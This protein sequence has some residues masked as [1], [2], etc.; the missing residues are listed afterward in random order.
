MEAIQKQ[1]FGYFNISEKIVFSTYNED[2]LSAFYTSIVSPI[3][4]QMGEAF[5]YK[6]FTEREKSYGNKIAFVSSKLQYTSDKTKVAIVQYLA[7]TGA[8]TINEMRELFGLGAI[9]GGERRVESLNFVDV[10]IKNDYQMSMSKSN[11]LPDVPKNDDEGTL[12]GGETMNAGG[13]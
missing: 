7:P 8:L 6:V 2:E 10:S 4:K 1:V 3:L 13:T 11:T 5:T 9:E 12:E